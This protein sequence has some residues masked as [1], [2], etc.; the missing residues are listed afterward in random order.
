MF[1]LPLP[2][3]G[4]APESPLL[5]KSDCGDG[6]VDGGVGITGEVMLSRTSGRSAASE[7]GVEPGV[8]E[9]ISRYGSAS[10]GDSAN[11]VCG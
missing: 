3:A 10:P 9:S 8:D 1:S 6:G 5:S 4:G 11:G 7:G 2:L